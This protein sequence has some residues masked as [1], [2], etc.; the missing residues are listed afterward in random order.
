[1][2]PNEHVCSSRTARANKLVVVYCRVMR[3]VCFAAP[4]EQIQKVYTLVRSSL[5]EEIIGYRVFDCT[6]SDWIALH[7]LGIS[8]LLKDV[9]ETRLALDMKSQ[10]IAAIQGKL[11]SMGCSDLDISCLSLADNER[12]N[13]RLTEYEYK[14]VFDRCQVETAKPY[15]VRLFNMTEETVGKLELSRFQTYLSPPNPNKTSCIKNVID[16]EILFS[17]LSDYFPTISEKHAWE[18]ERGLT[19]G[20]KRVIMPI[21]PISSQDEIMML[22][23]MLMNISLALMTD[24]IEEL[25]AWVRDQ[26]VSLGN[27]TAELA[28]VQQVSEQKVPYVYR[29]LLTIPKSYRLIANLHKEDPEIPNVTNRQLLSPD[30]R[31]SFFVPNKLQHRWRESYNAKCR[32][33]FKLVNKENFQN[34][35]G[36]LCQWFE[37]DI[38]NAADFPRFFFQCHTPV[39]LL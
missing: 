23:D 8:D 36:Q 29:L 26:K 17:R 18:R 34:A 13:R 5:Q 7:N 12:L 16:W 9:E 11:R 28:K 30:W 6:K 27:I 21:K 1:M 37:E 14:F 2:A 20:Q 33:F 3:D 31:A 22:C 4:P 24:L 10:G 25:Q 39:Y 38:G 35:A 32:E 15:L 19:E